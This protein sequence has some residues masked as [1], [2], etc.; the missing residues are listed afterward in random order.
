[1]TRSGAN[2]TNHQKKCN[3]F[4]VAMEDICHFDW[5]E[6]ASFLLKHDGSMNNVKNGF[7]PIVILFIFFPRMANFVQN[8]TEYLP[9]DPKMHIGSIINAIC[10]LLPINLE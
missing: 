4:C 1:M 8:N 2:V 10:I 3:F 5:D 9:L 7:Y 6:N